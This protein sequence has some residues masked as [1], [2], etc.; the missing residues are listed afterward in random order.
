MSHNRTKNSTHRR[1]DY[2]HLAADLLRFAIIA[3]L[4]LLA[5]VWMLDALGYVRH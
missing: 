5:L 3:G 1:A 2:L 4:Q